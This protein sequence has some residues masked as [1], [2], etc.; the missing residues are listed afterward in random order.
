MWKPFQFKEQDIAFAHGWGI[1]QNSASTSFGF[2]GGGVSAVRVFPEQDLAI[3]V[4]TNGYRYFSIHNDLVNGI[5]SRLFPE[6]RSQSADL[7]QQTI[8]QF[9]SDEFLVAAECY[10]TLVNEHPKVAS[11]GFFN[12][13]GYRLMAM[14]KLDAAVSI[15]ERNTVQF[16]NSSN[17]YDSL[18]EAYL[19]QGEVRKALRQYQKALALNPESQNAQRM[20]ERLEADRSKHL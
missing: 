18:G 13:L 17:V 9:I 2:T 5:A 15:F 1:Y 7:F 14:D 12:R 10:Q 16:P 3:V 19:K 6:L 4:L 8:K 11:E 20:I